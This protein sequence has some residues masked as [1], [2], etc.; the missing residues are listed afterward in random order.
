MTLIQTIAIF[1]F[2]DGLQLSNSQVLAAEPACDQ[3][4]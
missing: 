4:I 1:W 3:N 2:L